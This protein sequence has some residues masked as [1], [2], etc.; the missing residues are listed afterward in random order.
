MAGPSPVV[1]TIRKSSSRLILANGLLL[2]F[3]ALVPFPTK[4]VGQFIQTGADN[5]AV[6]F[7]TGYFLLVSFAFLV[8]W[9]VASSKTKSLLQPSVTD[10]TVSSFNRSYWGGLLI[11]LACFG[12]SFSSPWLGITANVLSWIYWAVSFRD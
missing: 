1:Q 12:L 6:E 5:V 3:V 9:N 4:T 11:N 8:V 10:Q 2:L 7:Y